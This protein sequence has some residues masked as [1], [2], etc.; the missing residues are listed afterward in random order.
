MPMRFLEKRSMSQFYIRRRQRQS[1]LLQSH[2]GESEPGPK[3]TAVENKRSEAQPEDK[4]SM[5]N[6]QIVDEVLKE[7]TPQAPS[8]LAWCTNQYLGGLEPLLL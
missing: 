3:L 5:P 6:T 7:Q 4:Q 2:K 1:K 8:F